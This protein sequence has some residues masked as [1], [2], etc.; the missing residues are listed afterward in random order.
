MRLLSSVAGYYRS[1]AKMIFADAFFA[2]SIEFSPFSDA[3]PQGF[4]PWATWLRH[5]EDPREE[6]PRE[7]DP[8]AFHEGHAFPAAADDEEDEWRDRL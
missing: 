5:E 4:R 1:G 8:D 2:V 3:R 6:D 7:E